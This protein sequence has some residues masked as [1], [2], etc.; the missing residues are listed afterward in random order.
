METESAVIDEVGKEEVEV[1]EEPVAQDDDIIQHESEGEMDGGDGEPQMIAVDSDGQIIATGA[2]AERLIAEQQALQQAEANEQAGA[3]GEVG[4]MIPADVAEEQMYQA[5]ADQQMMEA[6]TGE[7]MVEP[8]VSASGT[9]ILQQAFVESGAGAGSEDRA[10]VPDHFNAPSAVDMVA[11]AVAEAHHETLTEGETISFAEPSEA[12][13]SGALKTEEASTSQDDSTVQEQQENQPPLGSCEN[14]IQIIQQG[15]TYHSTQMLSPDQLQQIAHVLQQQQVSKAIQNGGSAVVYN[16]QTN[17]RIIYR[18]LY[19]GGKEKGSGKAT[20]VRAKT[21]PPPKQHPK[22]Y[23]GRG[24]PAKR[25]DDDI[26]AEGPSLSREERDVIKR[27]APR[28]RSGRISRPPKYMVRDYKRIHHLDFHEEPPPDESDGGYSDIEVEAGEDGVKR[29]KRKLVLGTDLS[30]TGKPKAFKCSKCE[31]SYI[32]ALRLQKHFKATD[33]GDPEN[34]PPPVSV[35]EIVQSEE[36]EDEVEEKKESSLKKRPPQQPRSYAEMVSTRRKNKLREALRACSER[37]V[38][39][40]CLHRVAQ[41]STMWQFLLAKSEDGDPPVPDVPL[42]LVNLETLLQQ[43]EKLGKEFLSATNDTEGDDLVELVDEMV[44][45]SLGNKA[46]GMYRVSRDAYNPDS[47]F[48]VK[49]NPLYKPSKRTP[50]RTHPM[51]SLGVHEGPSHVISQKSSPR[52]GPTPN[53]VVSNRPTPVHVPKA[54]SVTYTPPQMQ[55]P[56][57]VRRPAHVR[58]TSYVP[59]PSGVTMVPQKFTPSIIATPKP[60]FKTVNNVASPN[61]PRPGQSLLK[62][63][64][65]PRGG[66]VHRVTPQS[67]RAASLLTPSAPQ[68]VT[69]AQHMANT[70][71]V[72]NVITAESSDGGVASLV[73]GEIYED[74]NGQQVVINEDGTITPVLQQVETP[75]EQALLEQ[76]G[77]ALEQ[78]I[79]G[80]SEVAEEDEESEGTTATV[81]AVIGEGD[82]TVA[83]ALAPDA[84]GVMCKQIVLADGQVLGTCTSN[85]E[86]SLSDG[87]QL[88]Q[89]DDGQALL[90]PVQGNIQVPLDTVRALFNIE[91]QN[92]EASA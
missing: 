33:H 2:E 12:P 57:I 62:S 14:P 39:D 22:G 85:G 46:L 11:Q 66:N 42:M 24:R 87:V 36:D 16:P 60:T 59:V 31:R 55:P 44:A 40:V 8:H 89:Q 64:V 49:P 80:D 84:S 41:A 86:I 37:E 72:A 88:I 75:E 67:V 10:G 34:I 9:D 82:A 77:A 71:S 54:P 58:T 4:R 81:T 27:Q 13:E 20:L 90:Q 17:T 3:L 65:S 1:E 30:L 28:T 56:S 78:A 47:D 25:D 91:Q 43:T 69:P 76:E 7:S 23:K 45:A 26:N 61:K 19:P 70:H 92:I 52:V 68:S 48:L 63:N 35:E 38:L 50:V 73:V 51:T 32:S 79:L 15:N 53:V 18:V 83:L 29:K 6:A 21:K 5:A 74:E